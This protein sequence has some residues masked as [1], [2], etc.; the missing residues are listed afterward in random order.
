MCV[1]LRFKVGILCP[2]LVYGVMG[3]N[4]FIDAD[5]PFSI[6]SKYFS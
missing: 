1:G 4:R 2:R 6:F 3:R 5:L